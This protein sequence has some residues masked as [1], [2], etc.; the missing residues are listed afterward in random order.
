M[1]GGRRKRNQAEYLIKGYRLFDK[2][3]YNGNTYFI[4]GRRNSDFFN[5]RNLDGENVNKG[6][7]SCNKIKLVEKAKGYLTE[8]RK[9]AVWEYAI[10][11]TA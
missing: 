4:F 6:S 8:I 5:I 2:V 7:V 11:P 9:Q 1:K 10:P 3:S